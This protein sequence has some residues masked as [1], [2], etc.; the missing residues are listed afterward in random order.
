M[1]K[2]RFFIAAAAVVS[3]SFFGAGIAAISGNAGYALVD[4]TE[5]ERYFVGEEL[6]LEN[7]KI[8]SDGKKYDCEKF[9]V[10]PG[11]R[12]FRADSFTLSEAGKYTLR[13]QAEIDGEEAV[14]KETFSA[15]LPYC[16][17]EGS[18][19]SS[20]LTE[21][22]Y[23]IDL[24]EGDSVLFNEVIDLGAVTEE[25]EIFRAS[26]LPSVPG[27]ADFTVLDI[28]FTD[29]EDEDSTLRIRLR[30][31]DYG[32]YAL[33]GATYQPLTGYEPEW[34]RLHKDNEWGA[35]S[36]RV[37]FFG[38]EGISS[39]FDIRLNSESK[40]V[41][42]LPAASIADLDD[43]RQFSNPWEGF[44]SGKVRI[45]VTASEYQGARASFVVHSLG[46]VKPDSELCE[47]TEA[48]EI[49]VETEGEELP[50]AQ[51]GIPYKLFS[52]TAVDDW[53]GETQVTA[54][55]WKNYYGL[56]R[57]NV[58]VQSGAFVPDSAGEYQIVYT[59]KDKAGNV[60][61]KVIAVRAEGEVEPPVLSVEGN[62]PESGPLGE[63]VPLPAYSVAGGSGK[64]QVRVRV[65]FGEKE[66]SVG[67]MGFLPEYEGE[68]VVEYSA[69]DYL[70]RISS[71]R[72]SFYAERTE[73]AVLSEEP[74]LPKY[75]I[76]GK[77]YS[78]ADAFVADYSS[79]K[80]E[81]GKC[82]VFIRTDAGEKRVTSGQIT[83]D[84]DADEATF[85]YRYK[86]QELWTQTVAVTDVGE[87]GNLDLAKYFSVDG[88]VSAEATEAG[89]LLTADMVSEAA[90]G[91]FIREVLPEEL[92]VRFSVDPSRAEYEGVDLIL[93]DS[94]E[95]SL[96]VRVS[97][98]RNEKGV[99]LYLNGK[100]QTRLLG[101]G[102]EADSAEND[103]TLS[104]ENGTLSPYADIY[105]QI[106]DYENGET[107]A[108]FPSSRVYL[109]WEWV[110]PDGNCAL[111]IRNINGQTFSDS[112][113]DRMRPQIVLYGD[114]GGEAAYGETVVTALAD[115]ADVLDPEIVFTVSVLRPDKKTYVISSSGEELKDVSP[116]EAHSFAVDEYGQFVVRYTATDGN[117]GQSAVRSYVVLCEDKTPPQVRFEG[118]E[119]SCVVGEAV[120][121]PEIVVDESASAYYLFLTAP[122]G[123]TILL[124]ADN[125]GFIPSEAGTWM[126]VCVAYDEAGNQGMAVYKTEAAEK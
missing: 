104:L 103:F 123:R 51:A 34:D 106:P 90:G 49:F 62:I 114:Y 37:N 115:A 72:F 91:E 46:G 77:K 112:A 32:T 10:Y 120:S 63:Y 66:I 19:S 107:F 113:S 29:V 85:V 1:K 28:T 23:R 67:E 89:I 44:S 43:P 71:E 33:A 38:S 26:I 118:G 58:T 7:V 105:I 92:S 75:M 117:S 11:G 22:G 30:G 84:F 98:R 57:C 4:W 25:D 87:Q 48:P 35:F 76:R 60:A 55:V 47:D 9:L 122:S 17:F 83:A 110:A 94:R 88:G 52:A 54:K 21:D 74:Y 82:E 24:A 102:F 18:A 108:G 39:V 13:L 16:S 61:E 6:N 79:G 56:N 12:T 78:L 121:L 109:R 40:E 81:E 80:P 27:K 124:S 125:D 99:S 41:Y 45:S 5:K 53:D 20:A 8:S 3:L 15:Y 64:P 70:G 119:S 101:F 96:S 100:Y 31:Y 86:Q 93:T 73:R 126:L 97:W 59:A 14:V 116:Y 68:Y 2:Y 36:N 95:E 42:F 111:N 65:L 69:E 50:A